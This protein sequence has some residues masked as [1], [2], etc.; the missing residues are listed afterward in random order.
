MGYG[1]DK[2]TYKRGDTAKAY[3]TIKNTGNVVINDARLQVSVARYV[4]IVGYVNVQNYPTKLTD[5]NIQPGETKNAE[6]NIDIPT[7]YQGVS[8]AGDYKFTVDVYV[9]DSKIGTFT[10]EVK[11]Q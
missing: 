10:K 8:T 9:W 3:I 5:L 4:S 6:Y 1:T 7:E 11:V 2:D